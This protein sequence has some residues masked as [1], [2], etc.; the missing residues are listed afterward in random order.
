MPGEKLVAYR[1]TPISIAVG[2]LAIAFVFFFIIGWNSHQLLWWATV[3]GLGLQFA[4]NDVLVPLL[5]PL[6]TSAS[7]GLFGVALLLSVG[8]TVTKMRSREAIFAFI[9]FLLAGMA[10][11]A[12][13]LLYLRW[14]LETLANV[15]FKIPNALTN[16]EFV[17]IYP[18]FLWA[19]AVVLALAFFIRLLQRDSHISLVGRD[20]GGY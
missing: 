2:Q 16:Y 1:K 6:Y 15:P 10:V 11:V 12:G 18:S 14:G 8:N 3:D 4:A 13:R 5:Q 19:C 20:D 7:V 17:L 9:G